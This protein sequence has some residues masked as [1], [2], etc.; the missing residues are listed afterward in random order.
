MDAVH[1]LLHHLE[2]VGFAYSP[3]VL[4]VDAQGREILTYLE[5]ETVGVSHPWPAWAWADDTLVQAGRILREY[6]EAVGSFRLAGTPTWRFGAAEVAD[7]EIVCHN[8]L[9]PY[10]LVHRNGRIVGIIDWDLAAPAPAAWDL[11][12]S[13]WTFA[14]IH[15]PDHARLLGAPLD[16]VRRIGLLCDAYGL[17]DRDG[18]LVVVDARM[19]ASIGSIETQAAAGDEAF[20]RLIS[21]GHLDRMRSDADW[22]AANVS[23]WAAELG[24]AVT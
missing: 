15:T 8:D 3:R 10:N 18:F 6:H 19:H 7:G 16:I 13:A 17:E 12:W 4:G 9:A 21:D 11:A 1:E 22:L 14:P 5:G 2:G 23:E 20:A 24:S